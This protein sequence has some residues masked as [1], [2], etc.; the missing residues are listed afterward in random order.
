MKRSNDEGKKRGEGDDRN[1]KNE[2]RGEEE[3][4]AWSQQVTYHL[5]TLSHSRELRAKRGKM[6]KKYEREENEGRVTSIRELDHGEKRGREKGKGKR[7]GHRRRVVNT[8]GRRMRYTNTSSLPFFFSPSS[9]S[10]S[11]NN[12]SCLLIHIRR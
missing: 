7:R 10:Y 8:P 6:N 2:T 1:M 9:F 12:L 4:S 11:I 3:E 5:S